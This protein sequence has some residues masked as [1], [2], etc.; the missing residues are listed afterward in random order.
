MNF[1]LKK[2]G[3]IEPQIKKSPSTNL[4]MIVVIPCFNEKFLLQS[5]QALKDCDSP[6]ADVEVITVINSGE[7][8]PESIKIQNRKTFEE[9]SKWIS[10]QSSDQKIRFHLI[11]LDQL[12]KKHAGVGLARKIGMD[13]AV[14]RFDQL[15]HD[16]V[17]VCF[18]ADSACDKNYL[19]EIEKHFIAHP[20]TPGCAIHYEHPTKGDEFDR[21]VYE[22]IIHYELHLRYYKEA[23]A[24]CGLPYAFHTVGS[25][26]AIRSSAYQKQG[27]MNKKKAGEDFYFLHKIIV[28][29]NFTN[30]T[31]TKVIPSPRSSDRVPFGTGRAIEKWLEEE[32]TEL[33]TYA[34]ESFLV[35]K[36]LVD[37]IPLLFEGRE[38]Q[39]NPILEQYLSENDLG[40]V[41]AECKKNSTDY[42]SFKK[43]FLVW[44]D[45]FRFLKVVHYLRDNLYP[46]QKISQECS[47]LL[48]Y[49]KINGSKE[50]SPL[51]YLQILRKFEKK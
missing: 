39:I 27:G 40:K 16:G 34:F 23:M 22:G 9:A 7:Q 14:A 8:H 18:D 33:S 4:G 20:K 28:L 36:E 48:K 10:E 3:F 37:Q 35:I 29:G 51:E 31:S 32:E 43:R 15:S 1:Y 30:L 38:L 46:D 11:H 5:L 50:L 45:A 2:Y 47:K 21:E 17:I 44:F 6:Q 19:T 12:P 49:L 24:I 42:R 26:M 41:L 25:S 13:E